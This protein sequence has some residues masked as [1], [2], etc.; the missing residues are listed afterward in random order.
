MSL[1]EQKTRAKSGVVPA[2]IAW[3]GGFLF[4]PLAGL[5]VASAEPKG[6]LGRSHGVAASIMW[7]A[8]L[9][10]WVPFIIWVAVTETFEARV[11]L[12][13]VALVLLV[14]L[15]GSITGT[16]QALRG[17]TLMGGFVQSNLDNG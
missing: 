4:G 2:C 8:V 16:V 7:T 17:R 5:I 13:A 9:A 11:L 10:I 12:P 6:S 1:P 15:A 14:V 3:W